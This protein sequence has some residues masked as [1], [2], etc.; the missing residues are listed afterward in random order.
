MSMNNESSRV[1]KRTVMTVSGPYIY[2]YRHTLEMTNENSENPP[3]ERRFQGEN[4]T[5][6]SPNA[7]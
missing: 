7:S 2:I 6:Y 4:G 1:C 3:S 5:L